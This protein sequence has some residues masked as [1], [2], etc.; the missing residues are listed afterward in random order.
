M[1]KLLKETFVFKVATEEDAA[2][3]IEEHKE[4]TKGIVNYKADFK[5]KTS[6]GDIVDS[7]WIV[8]VT[9][10]YTK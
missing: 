8:T 9:H 4:A 10:D 3:L 2:K 5:T 6:K 1:A 7:W